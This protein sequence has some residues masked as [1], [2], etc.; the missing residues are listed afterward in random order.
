MY[1]IYHS[2]D[3]DGLFSG[4]IVR[5]FN[6]ET[7]LIPYDYGEPVPELEPNKPVVI[8][9]VSFPV[10]ILDKICFN[11]Y[12]QTIWI[13]HHKSAIEE[14][15]SNIENFKYLKY[16]KTVLNLKKSGCELTWEHFFSEIEVPFL[17][18]CIAKYDTWKNS[19]KELWENII[20]PVQYG[21]RFFFTSP[22]DI[23]YFYE[24]ISLERQIEIVSQEFGSV[25]SYIW[26]YIRRGYETLAKNAFK[27][28]FKDIDN[29]CVFINTSDG[30]S[31]IFDYIEDKEIDYC[32][33]YSRREN[34]YKFSL[35]SP[36]RH[37]DCSAIAKKYKG[38]G[39]PG[40]SGF[41]SK[42]FDSIFTTEGF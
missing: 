42:D 34:G 22:Y 2:K 7:I 1:C 39:H 29:T 17:I 21:C 19:E 23:N 27:G 9:D 40:A 8:C 3:L 20:L 18:Q 5:Y 32:V 10:D 36:F 14:F 25:G 38:G 33:I 16:V 6:P 26:E 15:N 24:K 37:L 30:N 11:S 4:A 13:D 31:L 12:L 41:F 35:Y 28:K